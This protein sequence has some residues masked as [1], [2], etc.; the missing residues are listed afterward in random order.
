MRV[1]IIPSSTKSNR[2]PG[3]NIALVNGRPMMAYPVEAAQ[4]SGMFD[5]IIVSTADPEI[6]EIAKGLGCEVFPSPAALRAKTSTVAGVCR[7]VLNVL[8]D[9]KK[10]EVE[11]FC[12][13]FATALFL[14]PDDFHKSF[15]LL[16]QTDFVMG[17]SAFNFE[18]L[19]ALVEKNG[20]LQ[21][22]YPKSFKYKSHSLPNPR[23]VSSNG[24][25]TWCRVPPFLALRTFYGP[26]LLGYE[27]PLSRCVDIDT[28]ED[29]ELARKLM[30]VP[31][32]ATAAQ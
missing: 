31:I 11:Y 17:V 2:L 30:P 16:T 32:P 24:T 19:H 10:V 28:P 13:L 14:K 12:C 26:R 29:C 22:L 1:A 8:A 6:M 15:E 4:K 7:N 5:R 21:K 18:P 25:L 27:I 9:V 20:Y 23:Q 3:K